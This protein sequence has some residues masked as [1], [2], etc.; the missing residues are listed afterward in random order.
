M[1]DDDRLRA[2][3]PRE[4][5]AHCRA[6]AACLRLVARREHDAG[7]DDHRPP[8]QARVV[9]LLHRRVERVDVG[10]QDRRL[11]HCERMFA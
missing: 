8:A 4:R 7:A 3:S 11:V 2:E 1:R 5:A 10:V 6:H 9:A